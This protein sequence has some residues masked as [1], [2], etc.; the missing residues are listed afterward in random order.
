M[1][2]LVTGAFGNLGTYCVQELLRQKHEVRC[3]HRK[4]KRAE[5]I[6]SKFSGQVD[7]VWGDVRD[8][9]T[10]RRATSD[11]E[12]IIHLAYILPP[13]SDEQPLLAQSINVDGTRNL[14]ELAQQVAKPPWFLFASSFV[15]FGHTQQQAPPRRIIDPVAITDPYSQ[16]KLICENLVAGSGLKWIQTVEKGTVGVSHAHPTPWRNPPE[17]SVAQLAKHDIKKRKGCRRPPRC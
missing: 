1:K 2:A 11:Q 4:S 6:A 12:V 8:V 14:I 7:V 16:H 9:E 17:P 5:R 13:A 10:V 3:L 15:V